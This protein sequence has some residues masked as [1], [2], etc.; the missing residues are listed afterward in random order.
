MK[1]LFTATLCLLLLFPL[2]TSAQDDSGFSPDCPGATTGPDIMPQGKID[3]ET[4][5]SYEW[6]RRNGARERVWTINTSTFRFGLTHH[7]ELRLQLDESATYTPAENYVGISNA[8]IGT[9]IKIF[10]GDGALPKAAFLGTLLIPGGNHS[11]Y[12]PQHVGIQTHLLFENQIGRFFSLGYDVGAEWSGST[13]NPDVFFGVCL[14]CQPVDRLCFFIESY[15][16]YNS[17]KQEDWAR[18]GHGS[19]F[20]CMSEIGAAYMVSSR[21]QLNL[22]GDINFNEPSKYINI[23]FGLAWL[24]N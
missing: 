8:S 17:Q 7:A 19:H 15:N 21:L 2:I 20:N 1:K 14:N 18:P 11:R 12:L 23:G 9:K 22:Y 16:R 3:W 24:L 4:G 13:D 5:F 10:D 6:N